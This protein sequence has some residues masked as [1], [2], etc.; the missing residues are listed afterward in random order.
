[1]SVTRRR[2]FENL[3]LARIRELLV[4]FDIHGLAG[5]NK[6]DLIDKLSRKSSLKPETV[7]NGL[8]R[9]ELKAL[10]ETLELDTSGREKQLLIDRL[11]GEK[12]KATSKVAEK[13][14]TYIKKKKGMTMQPQHQAVQFVQRVVYRI[15]GIFI[16]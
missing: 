2:I 3:T 6:A 4:V 7:L 10:C 1:M 13:P 9:D 8:K 14:A 5:L 12:P 11:L 15:S 16:Q